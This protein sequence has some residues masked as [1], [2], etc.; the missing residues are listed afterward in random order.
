MIWSSILNTALELILIGRCHIKFLGVFISPHWH[1]S[2]MTHR[3]NLGGLS[4]KKLPF[5]KGTHASHHCSSLQLTSLVLHFVLFL[6]PTI[7]NIEPFHCQISFF[8]IIFLYCNIHRYSRP[9]D[10]TN[11][12][13]IILSSCFSF[14]LISSSFFFSCHVRILFNWFNIVYVNVVFDLIKK[15]TKPLF[16]VLNCVYISLEYLFL[17]YILMLLFILC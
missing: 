13:K 9:V 12:Y 11:Q 8:I 14:H 5:G 10:K 4:N 2:C 6:S 15:I 7:F 17:T 16:L 3:P 1:V